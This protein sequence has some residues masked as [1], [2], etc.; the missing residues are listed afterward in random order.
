[1]TRFK[2]S[3]SIDDVDM[4]LSLEAMASAPYGAFVYEDSAEE[5]STSRMLFEAEAAEFAPPFGHA[6]VDDA[7]VT[8]AMFAGP[9]TQGELTKTRFKAARALRN[10]VTPATVERMKLAGAT[11]WKLEEGDQYLSRIAVRADKRGLGIARFALGEFLTMAQP[12]G[13]RAILEVDPGAT[14]AVKLYES[15]GFVTLGDHEARDPSTGRVLVYRH[16][17]KTF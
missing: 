3:S 13:K 16:M 4:F 14:A 9:L 7:G 2:V 8:V 11:L 12:S 5:K 15:A 17:A 6:V 10:K 1:M